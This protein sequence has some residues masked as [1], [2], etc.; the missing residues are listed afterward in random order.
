M[1]DIIFF[2]NLMNLGIKG[3]GSYFEDR[4]ELEIAFEYDPAKHDFFLSSSVRSV[5]QSAY[6][7]WFPLHSQIKVFDT[8]FRYR[9]D[10]ERTGLGPHPHL[11][12][13]GSMLPATLRSAYSAVK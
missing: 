9:D 2:F 3:L 5:L 13:L 4:C 12:I 8:I 6:S 1:T 10:G 11:F 7:R